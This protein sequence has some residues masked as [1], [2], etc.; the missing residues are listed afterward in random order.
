MKPILQI[1]RMRNGMFKFMHKKT[2]H[3]CTRKQLNKAI[4]KNILLAN[5]TR[6]GGK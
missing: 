3:G 6:K 4:L 1:E 2:V 5:S